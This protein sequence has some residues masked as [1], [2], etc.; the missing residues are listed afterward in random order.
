M[1]D[2]KLKQTGKIVVVAKSRYYPGICL[3]MDEN[4]ENLIHDNQYPS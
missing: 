4:H 2:E 3:E 1:M